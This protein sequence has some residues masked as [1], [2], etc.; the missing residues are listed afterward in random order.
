MEVD[1]QFFRRL[2]A[3]NEETWDGVIDL[4]LVSE[5]S[6]ELAI[7]EVDAWSSPLLLHATAVPDCLLD[8]MLLRHLTLF[9]LRHLSFHPICHGDWWFIFTGVSCQRRV[10][11]L[12]H[13][14][15]IRHFNFVHRSAWDAGR[16]GLV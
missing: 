10:L 4:L 3:P 9:F 13:T 2:G 11:K 6:E 8:D 14:C 15:D 5:P 12:L 16:G 1:E 7:L